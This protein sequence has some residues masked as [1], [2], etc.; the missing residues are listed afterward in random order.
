MYGDNNEKL[1]PKERTLHSLTRVS[2]DAAVLFGGFNKCKTLGDC[3]ML[4]TKRCVSN[5]EGNIWTLC[6]HHA[7]KRYCHV[8]V[9]EMSSHRVWLIG[10]YSE[11]SFRRRKNAVHIRELTFS[12]D[13]TLKVLA[14]DSVTKNMDKLTPG[15]EELPHE[16]RLAIESKS[17]RKYQISGIEVNHRLILTE[18]QENEQRLLTE[19]FFLLTEH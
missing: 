7:H 2:N 15:I 4:N 8:A 14:L 9:K 3:W 19:D 5:N 6:E 13:Q 10:G 1:W 12:S 18:V 16:L 11:D 17:K